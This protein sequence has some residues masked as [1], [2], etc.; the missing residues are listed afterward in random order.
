MFIKW[1]QTFETVLQFVVF[2]VLECYTT[3]CGNIYLIKISSKCL[4]LWEVAEVDVFPGT[5]LQTS[6]LLGPKL[7]AQPLSLIEK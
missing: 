4:Y 2:Y 7:E 6:Y 1:I 3:F 5:S